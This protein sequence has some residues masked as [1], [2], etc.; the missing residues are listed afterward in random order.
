[1]LL[2]FRAKDINN[3]ITDAQPKQFILMLYVYILKNLFFFLRQRC[4]FTAQLVPT[5]S[6]VVLTDIFTRLHCSDEVS[7]II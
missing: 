6:S 3:L 1:M 4:C 7:V 2:H 5:V